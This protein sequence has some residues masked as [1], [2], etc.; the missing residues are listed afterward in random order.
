MFH[1]FSILLFYGLIER[2]SRYLLNGEAE[3]NEQWG[4]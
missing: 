3:R 4:P 1:D 2:L